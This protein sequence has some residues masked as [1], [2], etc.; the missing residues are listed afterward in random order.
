M[1]RTLAI[2]LTQKCNAKFEIVVS[3]NIYIY[4]YDTIS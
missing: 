2:S 4:I 1:Y 3:P